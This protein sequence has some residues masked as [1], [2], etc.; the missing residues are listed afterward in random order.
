MPERGGRNG[1]A[2]AIRRCEA[3]PSR[4]NAADSRIRRS[5]RPA[6]EKLG[7]QRHAV[8]ADAHIA[9]RAGHSTASRALAPGPVSFRSI[10]RCT[11]WN[12][13][14]VQAEVAVE[15][16]R[17]EPPLRTMTWSILGIHRRHLGGVGP[18]SMIVFRVGAAVIAFARNR[19]EGRHA[20]AGRRQQPRG[21]RRDRAAVEAALK[22]RPPPRRRRSSLTATARIEMLSR[23]ASAYS[24]WSLSRT[25]AS[26]G[27]HQRSDR[28]PSASRPRHARRGPS[29]RRGRR[30]RAVLRHRRHQAGNGD[31]VRRLG[32]FGRNVKSLG[33]VAK[34]K[35]P[36]PRL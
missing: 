31:I 36:G 4:I 6:C 35:K 29:R 25:G 15:P 21:R 34:A 12:R 2:P 26:L 14:F 11:G 9:A 10:P 1:R 30:C 23:S 20:P 16:A 33:L 13:P 5:S 27:C 8:I 28:S 32:N 18:S 24:L 17:G 22:A 19:G 3:L 7:E